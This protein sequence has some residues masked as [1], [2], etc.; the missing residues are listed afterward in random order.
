M[1][2]DFKKKFDDVLN[3]IKREL[4]SIA[5]RIDEYL[6]KGEIYRAYRIWRDAVLDSLKMLRNALNTLGEEFKDIKFSEDDLNN[7]AKYTREGIR[8]IVDKLEEIGN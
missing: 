8:E 3:K 6:E 7:I 4:D 1:S 2:E 5:K